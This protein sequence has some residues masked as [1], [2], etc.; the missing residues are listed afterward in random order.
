MATNVIAFP[1]N[2]RKNQNSYNSGYRKYYAETDTR[3]PLNLKGFAKHISDHGKLVT[4]DL[5]QL[6][7]QNIVGCMKE[8]QGH[9]GGNPGS[10]YRKPDRGRTPAIHP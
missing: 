3:E 10:G 4:F 7:L 6:V 2:L 5:A 9:R 1:V 8:G